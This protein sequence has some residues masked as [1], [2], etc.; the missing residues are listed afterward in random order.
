MKLSKFFFKTILDTSENVLHVFSRKIEKNLR[1]RAN[2]EGQFG[3]KKRIKKQG[4]TSFCE[5]NDQN[6]DF[7]A[8]VLS[9]E[10]FSTLL[11]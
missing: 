8:K 7:Q 9:D 3:V 2:S 4:K 10:R 6:L 5:K 1:F 11:R